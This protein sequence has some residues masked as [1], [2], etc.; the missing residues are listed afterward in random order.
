VNAWLEYKEDCRNSH[1]PK[2]NIL[3][4]LEFKMAIGE[5]LVAPPTG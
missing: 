5:L 2:K 1:I 4:L 3:D